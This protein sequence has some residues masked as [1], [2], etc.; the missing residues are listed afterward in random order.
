MILSSNIK[1]VRLYY[2]F[3]SKKSGNHHHCLLSR[4]KSE[5]LLVAVWRWN[6]VYHICWLC[7][8]NSTCTFAHWLR[9]GKNVRSIPCKTPLLFVWKRMLINTVSFVWMRI[10]WMRSCNYLKNM[11]PFVTFA[12]K[13][14]L[15]M[16]LRYFVEKECFWT[17]SSMPFF[18]WID[19]K[20]FWIL[21]W[22]IKC[23]IPLLFVWKRMIEKSLLYVLKKTLAIP[24]SYLFA[25]ECLYLLSDK[26]ASL[27]LFVSKKIVVKI[28]WYL[29]WKE[30]L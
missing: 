23:N 17:F 12:C 19:W 27:L 22:K 9:L 2:G 30:C 8:G 26:N 3:P 4:K 28:L 13:R 29:F 18:W 16:S 1:A 5:P 7:F 21:V 24:L 6:Y 11:W 10:F 15:V 25:K 14:S 20:L